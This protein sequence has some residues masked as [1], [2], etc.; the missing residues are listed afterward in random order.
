MASMKDPVVKEVHELIGR[1]SV[2]EIV[3]ALVVIAK[4]YK[5]TMKKDGDR[6]YI[7][8]EIIESAMAKALAAIE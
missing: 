8:W 1:F 3:E 4:H 2:P 5:Q 6:E 7:G